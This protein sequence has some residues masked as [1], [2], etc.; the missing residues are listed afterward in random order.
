MDVPPTTPTAPIFTCPL[1]TPLVAAA[2][3]SLG[4]A[5]TFFFGREASTKREEL[6]T[7]RELAERIRK[8]TQRSKDR[9]PWL[10][11]ARFGDAKTDKGSLRHDA[12]VRAITGIEADYEPRGSEFRRGTG[13]ADQGRSSTAPPDQVED[14]LRRNA[15]RIVRKL[16]LGLGMKLREIVAEVAREKR[17]QRKRGE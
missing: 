3:P 16:D 2:H 10:K 7:C 14:K 12:N 15:I 11:L 9:L 13:A 4:V 1:K 17:E 6:L 8:T 5:V